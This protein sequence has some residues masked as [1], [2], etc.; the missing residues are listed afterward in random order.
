MKKKCLFC[1]LLSS[2]LVF[3]SSCNGC[4]GNGNPDESIHIIGID[5]LPSIVEVEGIVGDGTSMNNLELII[6]DGDT[7]NIS[8]PDEMI[9]GGANAGDRVSVVYFVNKDENLASVA[10]NMSALE[11]LWTSKS[12]DGKSKSIELNKKGVAVSYNMNTEYCNWSLKNG[13]LLLHASKP[14][15]SEKPEVVDTFQI[16][17][18]SDSELVLMHDNKEIVYEL[19]N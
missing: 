5:S 10:I 18:L 19:E 3:L 7:V 16:M 13:L 6:P 4:S 2:V 15:A 12:E 8:T 14:V 11:H 9:M 1:V 17:N